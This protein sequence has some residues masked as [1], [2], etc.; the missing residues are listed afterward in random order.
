MKYYIGNTDI[1]WYMFLKR[2]NPEDVNFWQPGG[3][4]RFKA[5]E[6]GSP[7]LFKLKSPINKIAG[8]GFFTSHSILPINFAWEIF[9]KRNGA[10]S[11]GQFYNKIK[12]YR[13]ASNP[14][15]KNSNIGCIVLTN[16]V[17]FDEEDWITMPNNWS[18]NIVQGKT[19]NT[20]NEYD[21][22]YWNKVNSVLLK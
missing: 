5:I 20:E 1:D 8:I 15:E 19:Y 22:I 7:F 21:G 11:Y 4:I 17:F 18:R 16:P 10:D 2:R 6:S 3:T 9:E 13:D 14:L 12:L